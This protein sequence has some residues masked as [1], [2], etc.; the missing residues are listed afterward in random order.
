MV[1]YLVQI[2]VKRRSYT[3]SLESKRQTG[4]LFPVEKKGKK[5]ECNLR[6]ANGIGVVKS[7]TL[8]EARP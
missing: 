5:H 8:P 6:P 2:S 7:L 3:P 1:N 4:S